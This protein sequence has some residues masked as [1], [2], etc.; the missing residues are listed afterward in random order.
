[1]QSEWA[2]KVFGDREDPRKRLQSL[3]G[4]KVPP[5]GQPPEPALVWARDILAA[6]RQTDDPE[7]VRVV[8]ELRRA[9]PRLTLKAATFLAEHVVAQ[10]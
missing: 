3:F 4:G 8:D 9:E 6:T 10:S 7:V 5:S 1:M 2:A